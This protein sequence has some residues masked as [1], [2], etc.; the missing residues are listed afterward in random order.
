M[1]VIILVSLW[2]GV[3]GKFGGYSL[4]FGLHTYVLYSQ[5]QIDVESGNADKYF[6]PLTIK[7]LPSSTIMLCSNGVRTGVR[8][9]YPGK[10]IGFF[11][12]VSPMKI[13][14]GHSARPPIIGYLHHK[15]VRRHTY[16]M[17]SLFAQNKKYHNIH[18]IH[19]N[20]QYLR[21]GAH[22]TDTINKY[23]SPDRIKQQ[24]HNIFSDTYCLLTLMF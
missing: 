5:L 2:R 18:K 4:Q 13:L 16:S 19:M 24:L 17:Y 7:S 1:V 10:V 14:M 23:D 22:K 21:R 12:K 8:T 20:T 6:F 11:Q 15:Y 9:S 3:Y